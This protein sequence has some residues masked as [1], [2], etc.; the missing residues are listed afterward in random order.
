MADSSILEFFQGHILYFRLQAKK[1]MFFSSRNRTTIFLCA[2]VPSEY[3][4]VVTTL[5]T[6]VDA[7]C[8]PDNDG[9]LP[10]HLRIDG[11]AT[12]IHNN[13]KHQVRDLNSPRI[14][15]VAGMSTTWDAAED[16]ELPYCHLQ[17]YCPHVFRFEKNNCDRGPPCTNT[18]SPNRSNPGRTD[19][20]PLRAISDAPQGRLAQPDQ[21]CRP[22]K[23]GVHCDACK[24]IGHE[25]TNC[26]M[27]A[28]ALYIDRY[29][30]N[31]VSEADRAK[32]K[33]KWIQRWN[34]KLGQPAR[35]PRQF[36]QTYCNLY[37]VT[38]DHLDQALDWDCWPKTDP[39]NVSA[40]AGE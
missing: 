2:V 9:I 33:L 19:P 20:R 6:S 32:I 24:R 39:N 12:L 13:A 28:M 37:N 8:H 1:N 3:A 29:M 35:T 18:W 16:N 40:L 30:K 26:N 11:I 34:N 5:Q 7:Y 38:A 17:G 15:R 36:M 27:L 21:R 22:F 23:A 25:A 4:N 31:E 10:G 14:H